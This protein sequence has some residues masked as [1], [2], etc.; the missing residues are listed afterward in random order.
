MEG[1]LVSRGQVKFFTPL[2]FEA[3][4]EK[5]HTEL[6]FDERLCV[7]SFERLEG[8]PSVKL[9]RSV[10]D[11]LKSRNILAH[12]AL[13]VGNDVRNDIGPAA[14]LGVKTALFAGDDRSLRLREDDPGCAGVQPDVVLTCISQIVSV[15]EDR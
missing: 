7:W 2:L 13:Y 3:L 15:I 11:V 6:G 14:T 12:E 8:K 5:T 1:G 4:L 9:F 10:I